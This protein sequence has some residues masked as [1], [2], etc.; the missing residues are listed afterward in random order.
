[1][2]RTFFLYTISIL[3][4]CS[5]A[6]SAEQPT[7]SL[8]VDELFNGSYDKLLK[9]KNIGLITNHTA[10]NKDL[11]STID[12][13]KN[14]AKKYD[15]KLVAL[16]SPE[17][18]IDGTHHA[19]EI[20]DYNNNT[21]RIPIYSLH[22][23][24]KRPT[25]Q[26]L[27]NV[28]LLIFDIQ[29]IGCRHYTYASTLFYA[30][31]EAAKYHIKVAVLD[32]PNPINGIT[33]DGP[34]LD[35]E[36]RSFVGYIKTTL[37]HGMTIGELAKFFNSEYK[38]GCDL[39]IIPMKGWH[40]KM[41]FEDTGL[42]WVPTSP[43]IPEAS[44]PLYYVSTAVLGEGLNTISTGVGYTLP[45]KV[46]GAPWMDADIF[47]KHLNT[48]NYPGI[49]FQPFHFKPFFGRYK[50]QECHGVRLVITDQ[51]SYLPVTTQFLIMGIIKSL[52]PHYFQKGL[53]NRSKQQKRM[54]NLL[55]G[56]SE[57]MD[58]IN[59]NAYIA[60]KLRTFLEKERAE[61]MPIRQKYLLPEY[62]R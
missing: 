21:D 35:H 54:F 27:K 42:V 20:I 45:F 29:D 57:V 5:F 22:G 1:M 38:I 62:N 58:I 24:T 28:D 33:V 32:R 11:M 48:Q 8:G 25:E 26:M 30:M 60:W 3:F 47:A 46:I 14:N 39:V 9:G 52:Y 51:E 49:Y 7:V 50:G 6:I 40:R 15:Y 44:T 41:S 37:C 59:N 4:L 31:E 2:L 53:D 17:H 43:Q 16:F 19:E 61:F 34:I 18:G 23:A 56:T 55:F 13:L 36:Q 12:V 10:I